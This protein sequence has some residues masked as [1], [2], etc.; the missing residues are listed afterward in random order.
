MSLAQTI[1][2]PPPIPER[3]GRGLAHAKKIGRLLRMV[4]G[5]PNAEPTAR[6][7]ETLGYALTRGDP[8]M[9]RLVEWLSTVGM[10]KGRALF[11]RALEEGIEAVPD[12]PPPLRD[13]FEAYGRQPE[14]VRRRRSHHPPRPP[15]RAPRAR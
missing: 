8:E 3:H 13:F 14:W 2:Q 12:A 11:E 6:E 5:G 9:D 1:D 7:W 4:A 10:P 15:R